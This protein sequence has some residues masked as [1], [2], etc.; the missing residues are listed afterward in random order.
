M[1]TRALDTCDTPRPPVASP[2]SAAQPTLKRT[3]TTSTA[4][5][6]ERREEG[7][8]RVLRRNAA[9]SSSAAVGSGGDGDGGGLGGGEGTD[10][11][12]EPR[13]VALR[14]EWVPDDRE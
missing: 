3:R 2:A 10:E 12:G 13:E 7:G 6:V 8:Q 9:A 5:S 14:A 1:E 11:N 4:H